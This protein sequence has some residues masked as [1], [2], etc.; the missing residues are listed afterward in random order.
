LKYFVS[1]YQI[2]NIR[3]IH[4]IGIAIWANYL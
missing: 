4:A 2:E 3:M 1:Q